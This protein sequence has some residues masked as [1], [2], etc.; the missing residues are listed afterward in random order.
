MR[1]LSAWFALGTVLFLT[2]CGNDSA[3]TAT[4]SEDRPAAMIAAIESAISNVGNGFS[5]STR[6][7]TPDP[8]DLFRVTTAECDTHGSPKGINQGDG[9]Y[10]GVFSYCYL[11]IDSG[12]TVLGGFST[13]KAVS[14]MF[15][16]AGVVYDG[17]PHTYTIDS[18]IT[19]ACSLAD[20]ETPASMSVTITASAPYAV[21]PNF[22]K[23]AVMD[24]PALGLTFKVA[25]KV[26]GTTLSF[27]T[28]ESWTKEGSTGASQGTY[29]TTTGKLNFE[30]RNDRI[31]CAT[32]GR[33]GWNRHAR[34]AA[35]LTPSADI[36]GEV[37]SISFAHSNIQSP[38]GQSGFGGH[39]I[40]ASG[41]PGG[42]GIKARMWQATNG[43]SAA[44][45]GKADY[46]VV[47]NWVETANTNCYTKTSETATTCGTGIP[48]FTTNTKFVMEDNEMQTEA[49]FA[50]RPGAQTF[51]SV[52][53]DSDIQ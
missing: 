50:S 12:D 35:T 27:I 14:C 53:V 7:V 5:T 49:W 28:H 13:P 22:T 2:G 18:T 21:N 10:P 20:G 48:I 3:S 37:Q 8:L 16:K 24:I 42:A 46:R 40:T 1:L 36:K 47:G 44:P 29:D 31:D 11:K 4:F 15:E 6:A 33:C 52:D 39:V 32:S 45:T 26:T 17:A 30:S 23:G 38:P 34:L 25:S 43:A 9:K 19:S 51:T 41:S